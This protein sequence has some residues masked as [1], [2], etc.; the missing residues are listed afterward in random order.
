MIPIGRGKKI[1]SRVVVL[2]EE[3]VE[4]GWKL[5]ESQEDVDRD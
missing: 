1:V 5:L 3:V 4:T 2:D